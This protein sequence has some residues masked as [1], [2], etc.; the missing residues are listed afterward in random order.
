M[1]SNWQNLIIHF[2]PVAIENP[3]VYVMWR[4]SDKVQIIQNEQL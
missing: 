1:L 3:K 4:V 2:Q